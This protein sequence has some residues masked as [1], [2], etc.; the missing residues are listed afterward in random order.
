MLT[1]EEEID[2]KSKKQETQED[3]IQL[4]AARNNTTKPFDPAEKTP[5]LQAFKNP[6]RNTGLV[7]SAQAHVAGMPVS[8]PFRE[9]PSFAPIFHENDEA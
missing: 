2:N 1:Q 7:L 3:N 8:E 6:V 5:V 4:I 9:P